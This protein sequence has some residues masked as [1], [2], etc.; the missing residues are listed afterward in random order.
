MQH[1]LT[2][3]RKVLALALHASACVHPAVLLDYFATRFMDAFLLHFYNLVV[4][5]TKVAVVSHKTLSANIVKGCVNLDSRFIVL[6]VPY[7]APRQCL[8]CGCTQRCFQ[9]KLNKSFPIS[10]AVK[11]YLSLMRDYK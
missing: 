2:S 11:F 3:S 4:I 6:L 8:L 1:N 7:H 9:S 5:A 10:G